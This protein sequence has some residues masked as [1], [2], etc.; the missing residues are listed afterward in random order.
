MT[1]HHT[2]C[3]G[4]GQGQ[5]SNRSYLTR[6]GNG[7][8]VIRANEDLIQEHIGRTYVIGHNYAVAQN[9]VSRS[10]N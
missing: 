2:Y 1:I 9:R 7:V 3:L 6:R 4:V 5:D 8:C 10:V